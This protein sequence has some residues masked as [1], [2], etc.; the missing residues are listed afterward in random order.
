MRG[1]KERKEVFKREYGLLQSGK[2]QEKE[3]RDKQARYM[4]MGLKI[5]S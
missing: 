4:Y 1:E 5:K 3:H 2:K